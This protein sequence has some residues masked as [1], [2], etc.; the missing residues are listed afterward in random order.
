MHARPAIG[1]RAWRVSFAG[2]LSPLWFGGAVWTH[3]P[4]LPAQAICNVHSLTRQKRHQGEGTPAFGCECGL[5]FCDSLE[6]A[7]ELGNE[8]R[9]QLRL[10]GDHAAVVIGSVKA[11]GRVIVGEGVHRAEKMRPTALLRQASPKRTLEGLTERLGL[12]M[13]ERDE[14]ERY[15]LW[16]GD[17]V[18]SGTLASHGEL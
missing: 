9:C 17:S 14:L 12:F 11:G 15:A 4:D 8:R 6:R 5:Y 16:H 7:I 1:Y 10:N 2:H 3:L 13:L 18:E